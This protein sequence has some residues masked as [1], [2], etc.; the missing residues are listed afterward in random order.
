MF[1]KRDARAR[2]WARRLDEWLERRR[3]YKTLLLPDDDEG[4]AKAKKLLDNGEICA[5]ATETVYG[6][7]ASA[8]HERAVNR[9][10]IAKGRP[11]NNPLIVHVTNIR[12]IY[13]L[14]IEVPKKL[15]ALAD[16]FWPGPLTVVMKKSGL[17]PDCVTG[18]LDTIAI[19]MPSHPSM[20]RLI[21]ACGYPIA[22][23][24][25]NSSGAPSP[26]TAQHVL[27]DL[28]G[29]IPLILDGG[30]CGVGVE[31]TVV[32][33]AGE[34]PVLLR[35]GAVTLEQLESVLG[36]VDIAKGVNERPE[37]DSVPLSPGMSYKHYSPKAKVTL[38][39]GAADAYVQYIRQHGSFDF[40]VC[41]DSEGREA[42]LPFES[43]GDT[44]SSEQAQR[45]VFAALRE[46]DIRGA[47]HIAARCPATDG[48]WLAL[49]NRLQRSAGFEVV[50]L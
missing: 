28:N 6:L 12:M 49:F 29:K 37:P 13:P 3:K 50:T 32:S 40:A 31:S 14:V 24:S 4:I 45:R 22:A 2:G 48:E 10:F 46:A 44:Q 26:T 27:N 19:R 35:P 8:F 17:T 11:Q 7:A 16:A 21:D 33:L 43:L 18:G 36:S 41:F 30:N 47:T 20:R 23:P 1:E 42:G 39:V 34:K 5:V 38:L 15:T 25:A 9:I